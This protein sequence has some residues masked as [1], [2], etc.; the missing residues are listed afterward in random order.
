[1]SSKVLLLLGL[2]LAV[3]LLISSDVA[4]ARELA[5]V[6]PSE[7]TDGRSGYDRGGHVGG[8]YGGRG[9]G[10]RGGGGHGGRGGG[11]GGGRGDR[12]GKCPNPHGC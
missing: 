1:M 11:Y 2:V 10:Y 9:G 8:G 3:A 4:S 5:S 12:G 7:E 6:N